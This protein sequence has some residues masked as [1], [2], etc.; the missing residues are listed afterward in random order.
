[1]KNTKLFQYVVL[2]LFVFFLLVG[3]I[4]FS[5]FRSSNSALTNISIT[6]WGTL[7]ENSFNSFARNYFSDSDLKYT[8]NYTEKDPAIFDRDLIEA[9][10]SGV[11]PDAIVLPTDLI[12]RYSNKIYPIPYTTLPET[13]FK[14]T[15][16]QEGE[17]YL[18]SSG[19]LALP[20]MV[21]P[22]VMY[23]NRDIF[24]NA[25]V[26]K[27][28]TDWAQVSSLVPKMTKLD[29]AQ[30]IITSTIA[31]GEYRN[32]NNS[33]S[34]L[35]ALFM[36]IGNPIVTLDSDGIFK[37]ILRDTSSADSSIA[38]Q[39]YTNFSN[40]SKS[41]YSW[42]RSLVNSLD[43]FTNGDSAIYLGFASEY[44]TIKNKNP[45][46]N[47]DV[48][49]LPQ[50]V[51]AKTYST[52]GNMFGLA[53]MKNSANPAGTFTVLT[54][55]SSAAAFPYW[56]DIF[57][58]PS[59]RKDSVPDISNSVAKT[60]FNRS[61]IISKGWYDPNS[62]QTSAIFQD[63]VESYTTGRET[64]DGTINTASGRLDSLLNN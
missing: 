8:V 28:P 52:F 49:L 27:P 59:A 35:S 56:K 64:I 12:L 10:A 38:L 51:G 13:A 26:T 32:V 43:F 42:N 36:Q 41:E 63:M 37:S 1:M 46:L 21:D 15:F 17:L 39:F 6:V 4:L 48:A 24:N 61:A 53:I 44:M 20:L 29:K 58:L 60:I 5:T 14:D 3:A 57:N 18:N 11:G 50:A 25:G 34:I 40:S 23:W 54:S 7:P 16:I 9:L 22:L 31:L 30:N 62:A 47:F 2:G 45:N 55:L 19:A 33:K